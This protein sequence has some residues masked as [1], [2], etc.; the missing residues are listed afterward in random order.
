[1]RAWQINLLIIAGI[2]ALGFIPESIIP[3]NIFQPI[4]LSIVVGTLWWVYEDARNLH[5][6]N[7]KRTWRS[8]FLSPA[9]I[10]AFCVL[11]WIVA[12]PMYVS[13]RQRIIENKAPLKDN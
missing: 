1:M 2:L 3:N 7:Y 11:L 10:T 5:T 9:A 6:E 4:V 12:F 8:P 13:F